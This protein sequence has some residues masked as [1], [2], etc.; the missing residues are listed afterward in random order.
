M[1][2]LVLVSTAAAFLLVFNGAFASFPDS[3]VNPSSAMPPADHEQ[4][5]GVWAL[6]REKGDAES[7]G[8]AGEPGDRRGQGGF[9]PGGG[10][11]PRGGGGRQGGSGGRGGFG[12]QG[13]GR[14]GL[15]RREGGDPEQMKATMNYLQSVM[16]PSD[17]LTVIVQESSVA[18][19]DADGKTVTMATTGKKVEERAENGL[20]KLSRQSKWDGATLVS[21]VELD[22]GPTI[23]RRYELSPSGT[24]LKMTTTLHGGG[25]RGGARGG[26]RSTTQA[27]D[28]ERPQ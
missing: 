22:N 20:V 23:E 10:S 26:D 7:R 2:R 25:G 12:R 6:N 15:G 8:Q 1:T 27:Y 14:G 9:P 3:R 21:T 11:F 4:F 16:R 24:E 28:R 18:I 17:R 13:G 5:Q 19:T